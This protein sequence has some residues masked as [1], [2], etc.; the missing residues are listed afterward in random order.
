MKLGLLVALS[1]LALSG[2]HKNDPA[3]VAVAKPTERTVGSGKEL[4]AAGVSLTFPKDWVTVDLTNGQ[5]DKMREAMSKGPNGP[6]MVKA[7]DAV[8]RSGMIKMYA[9]D[10]EHSKP[11]FLNN[12]NLTVVSAGNAT[13]DQALDQ[14]KQQIATFGAQG[15]TSKVTLP[16]GEFGKLEAH[17]KAPSGAEITTLGYLKIDGG[18]MY[19]VTF[20]CPP[21][22]AK[23][24]EETARTVMQTF[25]L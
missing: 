12:A 15:T 9:F 13:L 16:N 5:F 3:S 20:T 25:R 6:A 17:L 1:F 18:K 23:D 8:A 19:V 2:C 21:D 22:Q 4:T 7:L 10:P 14:S 11:G 24:Y